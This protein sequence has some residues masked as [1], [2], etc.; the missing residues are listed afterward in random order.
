MGFYKPHTGP[1]HTAYAK[2]DSMAD[3]LAGFARCRTMQHFIMNPSG[4]AGES[5]I[6]P[7]C[8]KRVEPDQGNRGI[9][10]AKQRRAVVLHYDC[11]WQVL[12][13]DIFRD[14]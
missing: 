13:E 8:H 5:I 6:C 9:Y 4:L 1:N 2:A 11:S 7:K 12:F 3:A 14:R 10:S